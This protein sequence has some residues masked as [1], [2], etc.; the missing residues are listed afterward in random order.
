[1]YKIIIYLATEV[2]LLTY[3]PEISDDEDEDSYSQSFNEES[4]IKILIEKDI[5]RVVKTVKDEFEQDRM[6]LKEKEIEE[7]QK[8]K[9]KMVEELNKRRMRKEQINESK[10]DKSDNIKQYINIY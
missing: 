5:D 9:A 8:Q 6:K 2:L 4:I 3:T 10:M 7:K 1:M